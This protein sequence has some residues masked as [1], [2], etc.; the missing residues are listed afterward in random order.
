MS[1]EQQ[2][3]IIARELPGKHNE[4][5]YRNEEVS[6][7]KNPSTRTPS[8][9]D[10][11]DK[12]SP[13]ISVI[14]PDMAMGKLLDAALHVKRLELKFISGTPRRMIVPFVGLTTPLILVVVLQSHFQPGDADV[15]YVMAVAR[16]VQK[17]LPRQHA[18]W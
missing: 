7:N 5:D 1:D 11:K 10:A 12:S 14:L 4:R 6:R 8:E 15:S 17:A 13:R 18:G 9:V 16:Y 3:H 2:L